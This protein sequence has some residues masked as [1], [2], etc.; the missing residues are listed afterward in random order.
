[1]DGANR[2]VHASTENLNSGRAC[3]L[4]AGEGTRIDGDGLVV[5]SSSN[6]INDSIRQLSVACKRDHKRFK[7]S[8]NNDVYE[9]LIRLP[10][11]NTNSSETLSRNHS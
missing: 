2:V 10:V 11:V 4:Q 3:S 6:N 7:L 8:Q 5:V 9:D 1:M